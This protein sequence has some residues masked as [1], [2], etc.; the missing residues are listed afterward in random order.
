MTPQNSFTANQAIIRTINIPKQPDANY[1]ILLTP[2]VTGARSNIIA[3]R[4][5]DKKPDHF[6]YEIFVMAAVSNVYFRVDY[7]LI[8][9]K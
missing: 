6:S 2:M 3:I 8:H 7:L 5:A 9:N 1:A 4:L